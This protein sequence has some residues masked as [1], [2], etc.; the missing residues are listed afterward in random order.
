M[1][2][3]DSKHRNKKNDKLGYNSICYIGSRIGWVTMKE[4]YNKLYQVDDIELIILLYDTYSPVPLTV[5]GI[6]TIIHL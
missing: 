5:F 1:Q 2:R 3:L 4:V 6:H